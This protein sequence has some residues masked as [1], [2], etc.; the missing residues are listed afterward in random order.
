MKQKNNK[1]KSLSA[2]YSE[3]MIVKQTYLI[4]SRTT[5]PNSTGL[6]EWKSNYVTRLQ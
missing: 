5:S 3:V 4:L 6:I 2:I 1:G